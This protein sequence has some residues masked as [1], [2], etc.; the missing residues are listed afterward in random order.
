MSDRLIT[1][2]DSESLMRIARRR[3]FDPRTTRCP[4]CGSGLQVRVVPATSQTVV[5]CTR[6]GANATFPFVRDD[7]REFHEEFIPG[8]TGRPR[9]TAAYRVRM[10]PD[11]SIAGVEKVR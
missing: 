1:C 3:G 4:H 11:G 10:R 5:Y 8:V 2:F 9:P 6:C 7:G